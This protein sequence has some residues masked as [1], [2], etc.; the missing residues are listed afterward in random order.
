MHDNQPT[1]L[2]DSIIA[3]TAFCSDH[4][5]RLGAMS[6]IFKANIRPESD[7]DR[8]ETGSVGEVR[9]GA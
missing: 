1:A 8:V 6:A 3:V 7:E 4:A 5:E 2:F 9:G